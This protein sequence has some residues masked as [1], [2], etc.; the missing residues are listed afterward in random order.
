MST[1][2]NAAH[3]PGWPKGTL[4]TYL[5]GF[6]LAVALTVIPFALVMTSTIGGTAAVAVLALLAA[7]QMVVHLVFFLHLDRWSEQRSSIVILV[8][9]LIIVAVLIGA[10][11]WILYH[12]ETN[13]MPR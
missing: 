3:T 13:L 5:A 4:G 11:V 2:H 10:T 8:Y 1:A 6:I 7:G 12:L 9:T